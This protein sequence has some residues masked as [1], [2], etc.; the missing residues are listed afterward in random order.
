MGAMALRAE[1]DGT[2]GLDAIRAKRAMAPSAEIHCAYGREMPKISS[3][4]LM[5]TVDPVEGDSYAGSVGLRGGDDE[6]T[7]ESWSPGFSRSG[8][9]RS[10]PRL[11]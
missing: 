2:Y 7:S 1:I 3:R 5:G 9:A 6:G 10:Q 11:V 4:D 8:V